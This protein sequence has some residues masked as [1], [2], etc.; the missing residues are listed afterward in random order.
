[1]ADEDFQIKLDQLKN[2]QD[3]INLIS[4]FGLDW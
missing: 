3:F 1:M 4:N 2:M